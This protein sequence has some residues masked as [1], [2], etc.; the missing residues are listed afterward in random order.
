M[1]NAAVESAGAGI[2][3]LETLQELNRG[4][5]RAAEAS[6]VA[7]YAD[8]LAEDFLST[9]PDGSLMDRAAFLTRMARPYPGSHAEPVDVRIRILGDVALIHAGFRDRKPDGQVG[10]GRYTDIWA[11]RG[12]RWLCV[13]AHFAR[14]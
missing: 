2:H 11:R 13:S 5:V 14:G 12:D 7:W 4:Y 8:N 9:N 3:D 1:Q 10:T 6:D